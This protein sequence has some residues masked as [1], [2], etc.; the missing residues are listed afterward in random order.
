MKKF[1]FKTEKP[2]GRYKSFQPTFHYIKLD[3]KWVGNITDDSPHQ[4]RL[5]VIKKD[6]NENGNPNCSWKWVALKKQFKSLDEAKEYLNKNFN[7][8]LT[9]NIYKSE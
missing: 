6:I 2:T 1:T 4:V 9:L 5:Q 8:I 7:Q 3:G